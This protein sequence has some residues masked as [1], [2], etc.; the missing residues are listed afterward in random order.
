MLFNPLKSIFGSSND[1][2]IRSLN[3]TISKVNHFEEKYENMP[4]L[5]LSRQTIILKERLANGES[6]DDVLIEAFATV[7]EASSRVLKMRHFDVQLLGGL[8]LHQGKIAEMKTGE[9]KTLVATLAAYLNALSG[10]GVHIITVNDYLARRDAQW[11]AP[12]Y[13]YLGLSVG[14]IQSYQGHG[15]ANSFVINADNTEIKECQR[16]EA[17]QADI[18]YGTN[19]EFGF[20]YLRSNMGFE[21][22]DRLR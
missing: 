19:N 8:V 20:D 10:E 22:E 13:N 18:T 1:R 6:I 5:E 11:M 16:V 2:A 15:H 17:Y 14:I 9:G 21:V 3:K 4:D 12:L 7:Q